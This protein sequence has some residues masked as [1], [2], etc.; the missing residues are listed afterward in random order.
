MTSIAEDL[1]TWAVDFKPT[2]QDVE[3]A[4]RS[5]LD[6]IAVTIA[7]RNEPI[8][9]VVSDLSEATRWAVLGHVL[10]FDDLHM[11]STAH[12]S[13]VCVSAALATGGDARSYL[14]GAGVMARLGIALGWSHYSSGWHTDAIRAEFAP[15]ATDS[16]KDQL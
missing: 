8:A 4:Q 13:V 2:T 15:K 16:T 7:A 1:A 14:T 9:R 5:L 10:D 12:I 11:E 6:T 3:L